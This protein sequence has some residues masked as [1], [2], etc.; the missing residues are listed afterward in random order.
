MMQRYAVPEIDRNINEHKSI[1]MIYY[2][3]V[4]TVCRLMRKIKNA[5]VPQSGVSCMFP[6][7]VY[8]L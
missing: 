6:A 4:L 1:Q 3:F 8:I 7:L 2:L 5:T